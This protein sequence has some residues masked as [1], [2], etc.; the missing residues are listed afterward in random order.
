MMAPY[1]SSKGEQRATSLSLKKTP[2]ADVSA[3]PDEAPVSAPETLNMYMTTTPGHSKLSDPSKDF[4][5]RIKVVSPGRR[6]RGQLRRY[7]YLPV[8]RNTFRICCSPGVWKLFAAV[9]RKD[10]RN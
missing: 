1:S 6:W 7:S 3:V 8:D 5:N 10:Q 2:S 9:R 4:D